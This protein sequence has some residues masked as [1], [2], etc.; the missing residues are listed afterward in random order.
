VLGFELCAIVSKMGVVLTASR[1]ALRQLV[2][3]TAGF[4]MPATATL[5]STR[6]YVG[7]VRVTTPTSAGGGAGGKE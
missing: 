4:P 1:H 3:I 6:T 7:V 5:G 2:A